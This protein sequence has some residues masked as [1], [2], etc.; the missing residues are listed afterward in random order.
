MKTMERAEFFL[1]TIDRTLASRIHQ[2][3]ETT[4]NLCPIVE[5]QQLL[6][7]LECLCSG[8]G[9]PAIET[10]ASE[11][12]QTTSPGLWYGMLQRRD[13]IESQH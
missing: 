12:V 6:C 2:A 4:E 9:H 8:V 7:Y 5:G 11:W 13:P 10:V 1:C 3:A